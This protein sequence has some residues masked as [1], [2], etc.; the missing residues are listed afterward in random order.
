MQL[1]RIELFDWL[2]ENLPKTKLDLANSSI[3]GLSFNEFQ[4]LT[5]FKLPKKFNFGKN[6]PFGA[7]ELRGALASI[8]NCDKENIVTTT[9][10]SE[11]NFL[12]FLAMLKNGDE[13]IVEQP[14]YPPLW[15]VPQMLGA[16]II[17][18][19]RRFENNFEL[20]IMDLKQKISN[21]TKLIVI[22]NLH[23]PSGVLVDIH[24]IQEIA[25]LAVK[26]DALLLI[27]EMFLDAANIPQKSAVSTGGLDS[28]SM[29][30]T[31]SVSKVY[32][33]GGLRTGW[34]I[35]PKNI[36]KQCLNAKWQTTVAA[37]YF[38]EIVSSVAL[39]QARDKLMERCKDIAKVN[40]PIVKNWIEAHKDLIDW[41]APDGGIMCFPKFNENLDV[42]SEKFG[43]KLINEKG[44][45]ISPGK[46]FGLDGYF[47]LTY[48]NSQAELQNGLGAL[49]E[50]LEDFNKH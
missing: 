1:P 24:K 32:G 12:V 47:R 40:F 23:N 41:V 7:E 39:S 38:S 48:L 49:A 26:Y 28:D 21:K 34:I 25:E 33:I 22:T 17:Y 10:G 15:L 45:L 27:D 11:A 50:I 8:Y 46:Y 18:W 35:A 37:P 4:N 6:D 44:V 29:I 14:G 31:A 20:D 5:D 3:T 43:L 30:V 13:V 16:R 36:A 19:E 9:G 42:D 2:I